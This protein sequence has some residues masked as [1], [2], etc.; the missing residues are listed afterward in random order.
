MADNASS[1]T[2]GPS[3]AI[4]SLAK[5]TTDVTRQ[6]TQKFKFTPVLPARR[7]KKEEVKAEPTPDSIPPDSGRGRGRGRGRG[8]GRGRGRG[9][10]PRAPIEMTASGPFAMGPSMAGNNARRSVPRSNFAIPAP[11]TDRASL[12]AG[13][14]RLSNATIKRENDLK[15]KEK[16]KPPEDEE[17]VYSDPDE[18]VEIIDMEDVR[19]MDWMAPESLRKERRS[20][21]KKKIKKEEPI[22]MEVDDAPVVE[23]EVDA[24]NALDLSESEE[25]EEFE[26]LIEHFARQENANEEDP[27]LREERLYF[28]QFPSPFPTFEPPKPAIPEVVPEPPAEAAD[29]PTKR[30]SFAG[31][32][33]P[34][35]ARGSM[36]PPETVP[37][38]VEENPVI[39]GIIGTL[40]VYRSGAVKMRLQN[41]MLLDVTAATQPSFLQH[42]VCLD[43]P[44]KRLTIL[45]EVNKRFVVSPDID[46]LLTAMEVS[47][48]KKPALF[49]GD[50]E[51]VCL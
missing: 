26:D 30:V 31:D 46:T 39:D 34:G 38:K 20:A 29:P 51:V 49:K 3:K 17:E 35:S 42:A 2:A 36:A 25:E 21:K 47:E 7:Q 28:F 27:S 22:E 23:V 43:L 44:Q 9:A 19:Q 48:R 6:G 8:E 13:L 40:E 32:T 33:K 1:S 24:A 12:G 37:V 14:T 5:K 41:G 18:G 11:T 16:D 45:G 50:E 10:A 15:G 4:G